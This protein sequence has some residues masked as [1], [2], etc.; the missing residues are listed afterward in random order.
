MSCR[1]Q[2][3]LRSSELVAIFTISRDSELIAFS[4][5]DTI[6]GISRDFHNLSL[7]LALFRM[8]RDFQNSSQ[9]SQF[10]ASFRGSRDFN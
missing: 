2:N 8:S 10:V 1:F 4:E 6:F 7:S 3:E 5:L 9:F